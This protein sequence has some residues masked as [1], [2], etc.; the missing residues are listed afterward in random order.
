MR[1]I[2]ITYLRKAGGKIDEQVEVTRNLREKD[3]TTCNVIL[4][5]KEQKVTKCVVEGQV[6]T[7]DWNQLRDYYSKIYPDVIENIEKNI[8]ANT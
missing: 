6:L 3:L 8:Q 4:D 7:K 2:L 5:F 1:Y